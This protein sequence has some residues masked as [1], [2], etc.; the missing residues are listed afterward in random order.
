MPLT[1]LMTP[2][3]IFSKMHGQSEPKAANKTLAMRL[4]MSAS[5][6]SVWPIV[7]DGPDVMC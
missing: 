1:H 5:D 4:S 2:K 3:F 7:V 6:T